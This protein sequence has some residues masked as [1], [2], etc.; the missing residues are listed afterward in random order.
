[1]SYRGEGCRFWRVFNRA[2]RVESF[3]DLFLTHILMASNGHKPSRR[4]GLE[5]PAYM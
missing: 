3:S 2:A 5:V 4:I 1:M